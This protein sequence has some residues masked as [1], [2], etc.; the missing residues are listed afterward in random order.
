MFMRSIAL[1]V[2]LVA[3]PLMGLDWNQQK[4]FDYLETRQQQWAE[5]KP[6]QK[7][8]GACVS[9]H[10]GLSYMIARRVLGEKEPRPLE[11]ALVQGVKTRLLS[12]PQGTMLLDPGPEAILSLLT[13]SLQRRGP[14]DPLDAADQA[15]MK[16]LWAAQGGDGVWTWFMHDLHPVESEH[17]VF[18]GATLAEMAL[19]AYPGAA[20]D[21]VA[22]MR[23]YLKSEF[24]RQPLHNRLAYIA[25]SPV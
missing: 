12:S 9:C 21:R 18:Y 16:R 22:A 14:S 15:G 3:G 20:P 10:T 17:S 6:T 2:S 24:P 19:S 11:S 13:L 25:L 23:R 5:W 7:A 1:V 4:A 8:G